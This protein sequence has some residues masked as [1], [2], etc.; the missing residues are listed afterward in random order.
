ML[1]LVKVIQLEVISLLD[2]DAKIALRQ[3]CKYFRQLV[4]DEFLR[5]TFVKQED[6]LRLFFIIFPLKRRVII[7]FIFVHPRIRISSRVCPKQ[8]CTIAIIYSWTVASRSLLIY[9]NYTTHTRTSTTNRDSKTSIFL[10]SYL[11]NSTQ[12]ISL[13]KFPRKNKGG[14]CDYY[15]PGRA[16]IFEKLNFHLILPSG[17]RF[18]WTPISPNFSDYLLPLYFTL[19]HSARK[20]YGASDS[21]H[22]IS[23]FLW[24]FTEIS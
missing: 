8:N 11:L 3:V 14:P 9:S 1:S 7:H 16:N 20:T 21:T 19:Y 15:Q 13:K 2:W 18:R 22:C 17:D 5:F 10:F 24:N 23:N 12:G 4:D 6:F